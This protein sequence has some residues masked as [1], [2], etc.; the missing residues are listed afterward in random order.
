ML[1]RVAFFISVINTFC[2][3]LQLIVAKDLITERSFFKHLKK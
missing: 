1:V 2:T 3:A